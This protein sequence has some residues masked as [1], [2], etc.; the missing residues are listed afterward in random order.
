MPS[1]SGRPP[2]KRRH[3]G[4]H[5]GAEA[6]LAG[7]ENG[8]GRVFATVAFGVEREVDHHDAVLLHDAD[9][10]DDAD[11]GYDAEVLAEQDQR[12]QRADARRG[13]RRKNRDRV[14]E[15]FVEHAEDDVDGDE[16][17]ENQERL[18]R[19]RVGERRSGA[20]ETR[21]QA[22]GHVQVFLDFVDGGDGAAERCVRRE[23]ERD[24]DGGELALMGD[25]KRLGGLL[26]MSKGT[27]RDGIAHCSSWWLLRNSAPLLDCR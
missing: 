14:D 3:G 2:S 24:G 21:L 16:R 5:D 13:Q 23:I 26:E 7:F 6:K 22:R 15:A 25:R 18:I 9:Q 11:Q 17:G 12:E 27:E 1:A 8:V 19:E 10:Q 4:H 20:L